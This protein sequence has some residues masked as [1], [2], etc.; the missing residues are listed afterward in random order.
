MIENVGS[1]KTKRLVTGWVISLVSLSCIF[2]GAIPLL[3]FLLALVFVAGKEYVKILENKGFRPSFGIIYASAVVYALIIFFH[4]FDLMPVVLSG[5]TIVAFLGVLFRGRQPY[6]ANVATTVLGIMYGA[7]LPLHLLLLRQIGAEGVGAFKIT[8][9]EGLYLVI[10]VF[11]V[12]IA[13][14]IGGYYFGSRF[15]KNQLSPT[16]SPKKTWEGALGGTFL[17]ILVAISGVLFTQL[18]L[19]QTVIGGLLIT[20]AAQLGDLSESLIKRDAGVKDSSNIL[21]GHGGILDRVD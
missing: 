19:L 17:A 9:N 18:T 7:W 20:T 2:L 6:I 16:I 1:N 13:T 8:M 4:R 10:L 3:L 12:V 11:L 15:G 5:S 14:D 21:P